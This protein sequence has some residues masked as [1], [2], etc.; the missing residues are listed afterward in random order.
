MTEEELMPL[1]KLYGLLEESWSPVS[2]PRLSKADRAQLAKIKKRFRTELTNAKQ[3]RIDV[4]NATRGLSRSRI[5]SELVE[6][7][8]R[9]PAYLL[10]FN[11]EQLAL[12]LAWSTAR[13]ATITPLSGTDTSTARLGE[14]ADQG[15]VPPAVV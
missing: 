2:H 12:L 4:L 11:D 13:A 3:M 1:L 15:H 7:G 6:Q 9:E 8:S 14:R 5:V 10:L